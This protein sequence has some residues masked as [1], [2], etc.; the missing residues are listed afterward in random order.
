MIINSNGRIKEEIN[1]RIDAMARL[2]NSMKTTF[3]G[4]IEVPKQIKA[5]IV[6]RL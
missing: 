2:F 1:H 5:I 3:L 4:K 6:K